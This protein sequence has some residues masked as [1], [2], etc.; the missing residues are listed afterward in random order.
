MDFVLN[1]KNTVFND[2]PTIAF[3]DYEAWMYGCRDQFAEEPDIYEWFSDLRDKGRVE[4]V[5]FFADLSEEPIKHHVHKIRTV[6][7]SIIDCSKGKK[8]KDYTDFIM[9]D[10][11]Y[12][13]LFRQ[14]DLK[15]FVLF[16]GDSHFQSV[17]AFLR[18]FNDKTVGIYSLRG[19]LSNMLADTANWYTEIVPTPKSREEIWQEILNNLKWAKDN[20]IETPTFKGT[21]NAIVRR[22]PSLT[23]YEVRTVLNDMIE[24]GVIVT[25]QVQLHDF[26][27]NKLTVDWDKAAKSQEQ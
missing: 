9:L 10:H 3:V 26:Y 14:K 22:N 5:L 24:E 1:A 19:C 20:G 4:D 21:A 15:Q 13:R 12:Q 8:E 27:V 17:C 11:I 25:S 18:N 23:D 7:N 2:A 6:S 16:T